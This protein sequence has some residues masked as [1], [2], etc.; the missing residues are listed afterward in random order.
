MRTTQQIKLYLDK[1]DKKIDDKEL[2]LF[3]VLPE[4]KVFKP[5]KNISIPDMKK[6]LKAHAKKY[7]GK[8]I[9]QVRLYLNSS[10][11][12]TE[13]FVMSMLVI[14]YEIDGNGQ[15]E[16]K[17]HTSWGTCINWYTDDMADG[18][19]LT[20]K[21]I[22]RIVQ[23]TNTKWTMNGDVLSGMKYSRVLEYLKKKNITL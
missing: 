5:I 14:V 11:I 21:F 12:N 18:F 9:A 6:K 17:V 13:D 10:K 20:M 15:V 8:R 4:N 2:G 1:L 16:K 22:Q 7:A 23:L 19:T 3:W